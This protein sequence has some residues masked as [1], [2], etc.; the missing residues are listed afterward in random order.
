MHGR[1]GREDG[2]DASG[3]PRRW[4]RRLGEILE[5]QRRSQPVV[6]PTEHPWQERLAVQ[7]SVGAE[8]LP[9]PPRGV[10]EGGDLHEGRP[11]AR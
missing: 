1:E 6:V 3:I 5:G 4:P 2:V 9:K 10:V 7:P 8:L 11:P